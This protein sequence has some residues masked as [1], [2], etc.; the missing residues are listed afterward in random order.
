[1]CVTDNPSSLDTE[2]CV[3]FPERVVDAEVTL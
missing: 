3:L 1:M 2:N